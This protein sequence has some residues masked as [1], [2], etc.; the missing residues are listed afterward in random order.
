[1]RPLEQ[2][3][4]SLELALRGDDARRAH[5]GRSFASASEVAQRLPLVHRTDKPGAEITWLEVLRSRLFVA[6]EPCTG[7]R[8]KAAGIPRSAYFFVGCGAYPDGLVGFVLDAGSVLT[9]PASYTPFDSGSIEKYAVPAEPALAAAWDGPA[10][11]RFLADHAG[12]GHELVAFPDLTSRLT[13]TSLWP[14]F[15]AGSAVIRIFRLIMGSGARA[16]IVARGRWKCR[17][18][19]TSRS[20]RAPRR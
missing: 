9:L 3:L 5:A 1:M 2:M 19:R 8:E 13:S 18:T 16:A 17:S 6:S 4:E 15:A 12:I 7:D 20:A 14:T 11:D 10:K